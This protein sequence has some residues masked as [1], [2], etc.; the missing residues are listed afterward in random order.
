MAVRAKLW[1]T[2][3][4]K[5]APVEVITPIVKIIYARRPA[6][7]LQEVNF[8]LHV[9]QYRARL[10]NIASN[11]HVVYVQDRCRDFGVTYEAIMVP[12]RQREFVR[13]RQIIMWELRH[14]F[15]L[16][17]PR[18]GR[19]FGGLDHTTCIHAIRRVDNLKARGEL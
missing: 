11:P 10:R 9:L 1:F 4:P 3:P 12:C 5:A 15:Q 14:K 16:S 7:K 18:I 13:P 8:D 17:Y 6:W 19:M 2:E